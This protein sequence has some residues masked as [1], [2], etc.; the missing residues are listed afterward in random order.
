MYCY[1]S[2]M[3]PKPNAVHDRDVEWGR[4]NDFV[5]SPGDGT[6]L[7]IV[8]G[9]RRQGK[10]TLLEE[11]C[12][13]AG[14]FY[15]QA[16]EREPLQNLVSLGE[17]WAVYRQ[18]DGPSRF[19]SWSEALGVLA[20]VGRG[21]PTPVP[22]VIDEIGYLLARDPSLASE[23]QAVL[24][25]RGVAGREGGTRLIL[26][27]SA[28]GQ[29]RKLLDPD[30]PL[31]GRAGLELVVQPFDYRTAADFWGLAAN[32][33][34]AFRLNALVGGTP[35]Y[36]D[37]A[38]GR[39]P[40]D[41]NIDGW[42]IDRLL[43][44]SSALFREGRLAVSEDAQL[45]DGQLYWGMLAAIA[46]GARRWTELSDVLGGKQGT[47][48]H[49][50]NVL[51]DAGWVQRIDDP[52]RD[53]RS[54][55]QLTEPIVRLHQL[56]VEPF[57]GR[58]RRPGSA[59]TVWDDAQPMVRSQIYGPHLESI[60]RGWLRDFAS[61]ETAGGVIDEIAPTELPGGIGQLDLVAVE[62]STNGGRSVIAIGEVKSGLEPIGAKVLDRL[63]HIADRLHTV[64]TAQVR[65]M[66]PSDPKRILVARSGFTLDV[67]RAAA[68]RPDVELVDMIRLYAGD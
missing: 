44:T 7:G 23:L 63:D 9:R 50:L 13:A 38:G 6:R 34:A 4:L 53:R 36:V 21:S 35:A 59:R 14:G 17:S 62:R 10:T 19:A 65:R 20:T 41:G 40:T 33:D 42:V 30:A 43:D 61:P 47:L 2:N 54:W 68:R 37:L 46:Q 39:R 64:R 11:L 28:F 27:G 51:I 45:G 67:R 31:R 25:P 1:N 16:R 66:T 49:A 32:P 48:S 24:S 22:V 26:C 60:A 15:W 8:Y 56:I 57:S 52:L 55:F 18:T 12:R 29:M 3:W 5:T 58:L